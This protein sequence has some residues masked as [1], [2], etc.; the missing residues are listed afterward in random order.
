VNDCLEVIDGVYL[1]VSAPSSAFENW[2]GEGE[3]VVRILYKELPLMLLFLAVASMDGHWSDCTCAS[4]L[5]YGLGSGTF[6]MRF[7]GKNDP[8]SLLVVVRSIERR[9]IV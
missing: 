4:S 2:R 8:L 5:R 9:C 7:D 1:S 3:I 6:G